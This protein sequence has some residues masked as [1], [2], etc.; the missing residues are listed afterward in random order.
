MIAALVVLGLLLGLI[1]LLWQSQESILFQP[2]RFFDAPA[3]M[4]RVSYS[5]S[6]GQVLTGFIVGDPQTASG[7]LLCFHGNADL[8]M[9][10]LEWARDVEKRSGYAVM[11]AEYRGYMGLG[12]KPTYSTTKLDALAAY[13]YLDSAFSVDSSRIAYFGHSLGSAIAVEL[14][15]VRRPRTLLLQSPF[16]SARAMARLIVTPWVAVVWRAVSRIHFDTA[17]VVSGLDVPV[18]VSHGRRDRI[19]PLRMGIDVYEAAR[20]KGE[21]LV[22]EKAGHSDVAEVAGEE[23]WKWVVAALDSRD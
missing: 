9:W 12:G 15:E 19:V 3:E 13:D 22:V 8:A 23:Y 4:G 2:P 14:A 7:V 17:R 6:D 10:Q 5:A 16:S 11:L 21:L 18:S 1:A 20:I